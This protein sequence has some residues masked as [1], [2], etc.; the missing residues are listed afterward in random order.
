MALP[1]SHKLTS[2]SILL[3]DD[4]SYSARSHQTAFLTCSTPSPLPSRRRYRSIRARRRPAAL[5][6]PPY[7]GS[8]QL[9]LLLQD[10]VVALVGTEAPRRSVVVAEAAAVAL[11]TGP[12]PAPPQ[13]LQREEEEEAAGRRRTETA[14]AACR[15]HCRIGPA[16]N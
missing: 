1:R 4:E 12:A 15:T 5:R 8:A 16:T 2:A 13:E 10:A 11:G 6:L 9:L 14:A 7:L 3:H